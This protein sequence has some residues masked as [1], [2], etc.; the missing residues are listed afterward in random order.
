MTN[1]IKTT[2][3]FGIIADAKP[4]ERKNRYLPALVNNFIDLTMDN[5]IYLNNPTNIPT[6]Y[7]LTKN[8]N[9]IVSVYTNEEQ[10][11]IIKRPNI[12]KIDSIKDSKK[13]EKKSYLKLLAYIFSKV[14]EITDKNNIDYANM[15]SI[16]FK[17]QELV[18]VGI[19]SSTETVTKAIK[20][21]RPLFL[22]LSINIIQQGKKYN[23]SHQDIDYTSLIFTGFGQQLSDIIVSLNPLIWK[24]IDFYYTS[25]P[26]WAFKLSDRAFTLVYFISEQLRRNTD[27]FDEE[28]GYR[29]NISTIC[30]KL[31]IPK[32]EKCSNPT[33]QIKNE[34]IKIVEEITNKQA[35][36]DLEITFKVNGKSIDDF[37]KGQ[38]EI[39]P[40]LDY[41]E[42][43]VKVRN[44]QIEQREKAKYRLLKRTSG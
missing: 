4:I 21:Y 40:K 15:P 5:L 32:K 30:E 19:Y 38:I 20:R 24:N 10:T 14:K 25:I 2:E 6:K 27:K 9:E 44:R 33:K 23:I 22:Q 42:F 17:K 39:K 31:N 28:N 3:N 37:L 29:M 26:T 18:D 13:N 16:I 34:V 7:G 12:F 41:M 43:F 11:I 8:G 36:Y 1:K 35:Y